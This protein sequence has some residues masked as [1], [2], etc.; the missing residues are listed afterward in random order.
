MSSIKSNILLNGIRTATGLLFPIITFPYAAR[1]LLPEGIGAVNFLSS[2][3]SYIVLF[4]SLGIPMY[5]VKEVAKYRDNQSERDKITVEILILSTI[6]CLLGYVVVWALAHF[7]P[8]INAQ[9]S[10]FY[11]LSLT[12]IFTGIGADWFYQGV[13]DF[14]FITIRAILVRL[15]SASSLF[16]FVKDSSDILIY[17]VISVGSSVGNNLINFIHL[18][19]IINIK[20]FSIKELEV[21]RHIKPAVEVFILNLIVSLYIQ[22]NSVM[23][24]FIS[25]DKEVGYFTAGTKISHIGLT[26]ISSLGTVLL[27][28]CSHL[29]KSG[30]IQR[31]KTVIKKS[32]DVTL[33]LSLPMTMG[34]V[35]LAVPITMVFCGQDYTDSIYVLILNAPVIVFIS[36]TNVMGIQVLYPMDKTK[37]VIC[38]VTVGTLLN[39]GLNIWLIP[40]CG[41]IGTAISTLIAEFGVLVYQIIAGRKY[42]PFALSELFNFRYMLGTLAM[43]V[44]VFFTVM[45]ISN[46]IL[47]LLIGITEGVIVYYAFLL[48]FKDPMVTDINNYLKCSILLSR[49][50][51]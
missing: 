31:F 33:A 51:K 6:L 27:P 13:E 47:K 30:D 28:R 42:Y 1:V 10:L 44:I 16:I 15:I 49:F 50:K 9:S 19:K 17:G 25:G 22:L 37:I 45:P 5:A 35:V 41:A 40:I 21:S 26:I 12:I 7:V 3:I 43:G 38:S 39:L 32:L 4:T 11:I 2:V 14:K 29:I 34:L 36:L 48:I 23:L 46:D 8:Q 24:G 20:L 18:R